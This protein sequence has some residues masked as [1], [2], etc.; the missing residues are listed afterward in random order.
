M[1]VLRTDAQQTGQSL[2][3]ISIW[4]SILGLII[5]SMVNAPDWH[6]IVKHSLFMNIYIFLKATAMSLINEVR[7]LGTVSFGAI[8]K[9]SLFLDSTVGR[10]RY[11][12]GMGCVYV[13]VR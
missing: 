8:H 2:F 10:R 4:R 5:N 6:V 13:Y 11:N 3:S 1:L 9:L 12:C 7:G